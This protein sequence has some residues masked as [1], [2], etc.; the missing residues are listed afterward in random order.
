MLRLKFCP[1]SENRIIVLISWLCLCNFVHSETLTQPSSKRQLA[2]VRGSR[3]CI[4]ADGMDAD[5]DNSQGLDIGGGSTA[6]KFAAAYVVSQYPG[7][8]SLVADRLRARGCEGGRL[9]SDVEVPT[10]FSLEPEMPYEPQN[11]KFISRMSALPS[12]GADAQRRV[13]P[14]ALSRRTGLIDSY[15]YPYSYK[16]PW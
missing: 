6:D 8:R 2:E 12:T 10:D 3:N 7:V 1:G 13:R 14:L 4:D 15:S 16:S 5:A 9:K 11:H